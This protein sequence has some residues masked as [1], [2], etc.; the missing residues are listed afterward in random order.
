M[1][2]G[3]KT[4]GAK[5]ETK[6]GQSMVTLTG[7]ALRRAADLQDEIAAKQAEL[8]Q[9]LGGQIQ[10]DS[11]ATAVASAPRVITTA[12]GRKFSP[13]AIEKI[14]TAQRRRW[15][16][17]RKLQAQA[18]AVVDAQKVAQETVPTATTATVPAP[19]PVAPATPA[20]TPKAASVA[21]PKGQLVAA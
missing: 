15:R 13:E 8:D 3:P 10:V 7:A 14:R 1:K 9:V 4:T 20:A 2:F 18:Q 5:T 16:N 17:Q 6:K 19:A 12:S 11:T 21:T